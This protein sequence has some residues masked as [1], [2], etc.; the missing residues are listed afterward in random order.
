MFVSIILSK[1]YFV[2]Q[3]PN[4]NPAISAV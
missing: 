4:K 3:K 2:A 1:N